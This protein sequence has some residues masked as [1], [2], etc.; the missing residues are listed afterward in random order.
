[1]KSITFITAVLLASIA[2]STTTTFNNCE[3][4]SLKGGE[5]EVCY[6][7]KLQLKAP[8]GCQARS[9]PGET[10]VFYK[11]T[12]DNKQT[13]VW[14]REGFFLNQNHGCSPAQKKIPGCL[15]YTKRGDQILCTACKGGYPATGF[16]SCVSDHK[17]LKNCRVG[18]SGG[19]KQRYCLF[20]QF[21]FTLVQNTQ[22]C[23]EQK[24]EGCAISDEKIGCLACD[25][26]AGY[27]AQ[28]DRTC[29]KAGGA[30]ISA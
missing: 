14:C 16:K 9:G 11:R 1:M 28:P 12:G 23:V 19:F 22:K 30:Q 17:T 4:A 2:L 3:V 6:L 15:Q 7:A 10:C 26:E 29:K 20:C 8:L 18:A 21:G 13:C 5:C 27:S 24:I 25:A